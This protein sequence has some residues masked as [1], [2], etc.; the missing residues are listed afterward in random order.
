MGL[1]PGRYID[2]LTCAGI[3]SSG[4]GTV[5]FDLKDPEATNLNAIAL[6]QTIAHRT[7]QTIYQLSRYILFTAGVF[8]N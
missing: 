6:N 5:I 8:A 7:E 2:D 3:A 1:A 4:L